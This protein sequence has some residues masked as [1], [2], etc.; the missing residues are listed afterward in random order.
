MNDPSAALAIYKNQPKQRM[1]RALAGA[2]RVRIADVGDGQMV[3]LVAR[4]ELPSSP[5]AGPLSDRQC[6]AYD[7]VVEEYRRGNKS[8]SWQPRHREQRLTE[9]VLVDESGRARVPIAS[10]VETS[11][12]DDHHLTEAEGAEGGER[13]ARFLVSRKVETVRA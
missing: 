3:K 2:R 5:L 6:A 11:I 12:V 9:F 10:R 1:K 8:S 13:I 7:A 4:V